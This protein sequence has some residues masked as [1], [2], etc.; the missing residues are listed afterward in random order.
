ML[1]L[2]IYI[3]WEEEEEGPNEDNLKT[4]EAYV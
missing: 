1:M 2:H 3:E 4:F